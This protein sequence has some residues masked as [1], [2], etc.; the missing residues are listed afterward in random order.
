MRVPRW[1]LA[2]IAAGIVVVAA[3]VAILVFAHDAPEPAA[4]R[5]AVTGDRRR[6]RWRLGPE[7]R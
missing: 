7:Q 1:V 2:V 6:I 4:A 3:D 5:A